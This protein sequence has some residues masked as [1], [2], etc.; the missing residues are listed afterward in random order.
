MSPSCYHFWTVNN[1]WLR[2]PAGVTSLS[3]ARFGNR[4]H[5]SRLK[6]KKR[7]RV[8]PSAVPRSNLQP[9]S[10]RRWL[11]SDRSA[12]GAIN[13]RFADFLLVEATHSSHPIYF[14]FLINFSVRGLRQ[15]VAH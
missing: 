8:F 13:M 14:F 15:Y 1:H 12:S 3:M 9:F 2:T 10:D 4:R 7:E 11:Q 6:G 5:L